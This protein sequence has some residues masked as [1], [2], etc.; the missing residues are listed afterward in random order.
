MDV[1]LKGFGPNI[2]TKQQIDYT[3]NAGRVSLRPIDHRP[4]PGAVNGG[5]Y[6]IDA[7]SGTIAAGI[8]ANAQIF[9][10][11]W[12]DPTRLFIL[13]SL[14]AHG[15]T[16]TAFTTLFGADLELIV[17]H[18]ATANGSGGV[19]LVPNSISNRMVGSMAPSAFSLGGEI[20]VATTA[21]LTAATGQTLEPAG[22]GYAKVAPFLANT[23][24]ALV[25]L[26]ENSDIGDHPLILQAGDTL[27][28]RTP[29]PGATGTWSVGFQ[30]EWVEATAY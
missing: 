26:W 24:G 13:K 15:A 29:N 22:I 19:A 7:I 5:H 11:R 21:A 12:A 3:H 17:G 27:V 25:Y 30:M 4:V 8:A 10:V 23:L 6:S 20:R 9:Q 28:V 16:A 2:D 14:K 1:Q 18:G